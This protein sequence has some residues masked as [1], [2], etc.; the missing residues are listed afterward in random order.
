M[1]TI[2]ICRECAREKY[3]REWSEAKSPYDH[4]NTKPCAIC[5]KIVFTTR[6][7][8]DEIHDHNANR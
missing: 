4:A 2:F 3:W 6:I 8:A 7:K 1:K 5:G